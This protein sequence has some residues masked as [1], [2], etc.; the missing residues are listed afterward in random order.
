MR[1][2]NPITMTYDE[3]FETYNNFAKVGGLSLKEHG[4]LITIN[5]MFKVTKLLYETLEFYVEV[6]KPV[7]GDLYGWKP[8]INNEES[9]I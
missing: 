6:C 2:P 5:E 4:D 8:L 9:L 7:Y 3:V 1:I